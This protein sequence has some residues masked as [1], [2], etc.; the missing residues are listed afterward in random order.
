LTIAVDRTAE[1]IVAK[2][3]EGF[4]VQKKRRGPMRSSAP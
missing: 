4:E 1:A 3:D 2:I